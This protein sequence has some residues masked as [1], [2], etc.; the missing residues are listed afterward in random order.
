MTVTDGY[1]TNPRPFRVGS[2]RS[3]V[4]HARHVTAQQRLGYLAVSLCGINL[5]CGIY[6]LDGEDFPPSAGDACHACRKLAMPE[7][8]GQRGYDLLAKIAAMTAKSLNG[9]VMTQ[10]Y[11]RDLIS[12]FSRPVSVTTLGWRWLDYRRKHPP[13][14]EL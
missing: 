3:R 12:G 1:L 6:T 13:F 9:T 4:W 7:G 5:A 8:L 14:T 2:S 10:L 11:R